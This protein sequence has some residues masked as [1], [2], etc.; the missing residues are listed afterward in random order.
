MPAVRR[1]RIAAVTAEIASGVLTSV[2]PAVETPAGEREVVE[3]ALR[4]RRGA[5]RRR[6]RA[7]A[8]AGPRSG[9]SE[10][11]VP[12]RARA[13]EAPTEEDRDAAAAG[14]SWAARQSATARRARH[15][16]ASP[17]VRPAVAWRP[18]PPDREAAP[19]RTP[20]PRTAT[21]AVPPL[22]RRSRV[23]PAQ[24]RRP[25]RASVARQPESAPRRLRPR[26]PLAPRRPTP[27][28]RPATPALRS[29]PSARGGSAGALAPAPALA[30]GSP[31]PPEAERRRRRREPR[32]R[33]GPAARTDAPRRASRSQPVRLRPRAPTLARA[34][35]SG[36]M[37]ATE[38][39]TPATRGRRSADQ[40]VDESAH[41]LS[42]SAR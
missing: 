5:L 23:V 33:F 10:P 14:E 16:A 26:S 27:P 25:R 37:S 31:V 28:A 18:W 22:L 13:R 7:H 41:V 21:A 32:P 15:R 4:S 39:A 6:A 9:R 8:A 12:V 24:P 2:P 3:P 29:P 40:S 1:L 17:A 20:P 35:S 36:A 34:T 38:A 42:A 19:K 30:L 11:R